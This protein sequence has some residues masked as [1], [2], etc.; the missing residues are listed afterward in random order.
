MFCVIQNCDVSS[1][2]DHV[3]YIIATCDR[4]AKEKKK[5]QPTQKKPQIVNQIVL[6]I[7]SLLI[8]T[9]PRRPLKL[10]RILDH[11]YYGMF[12]GRGWVCLLGGTYAEK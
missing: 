3:D 12:Q 4:L 2:S 8:F 10:I 5:K 9:L 6:I 11:F 7:Q 1:F